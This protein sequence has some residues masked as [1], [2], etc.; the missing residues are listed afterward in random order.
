[1]E[2]S[3]LPLVSTATHKPT[4]GQ[5]TDTMLSALFAN[6]ASCQLAVRAARTV[7]VAGALVDGSAVAV[8]RAVVVD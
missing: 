6:V 1:V 7:V 8:R 4:E 2:T 5:E 3:A